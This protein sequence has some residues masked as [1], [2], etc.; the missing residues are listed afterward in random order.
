MIFDDLLVGGIVGYSFLKDPDG[1]VKGMVWVFS[2]L[3]IGLAIFLGCT[4]WVE[5]MLW[6]LGVPLAIAIIVFGVRARIRQ[7]EIEQSRA[8][9][10]L[11][12]L[13]NACEAKWHAVLRQAGLAKFE[14]RRVEWEW[15]IS[16]FEPDWMVKTLKKR[17]EL[18]SNPSSIEELKRKILTARPHGFVP[19]EGFLDRDDSY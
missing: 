14:I 17:Q 9:A 3:W 16:G 11:L 12:A 15:N 6:M 18:L 4:G 19:Y 7:V 1:F 5:P 2:I 10:H 13:H 8:L